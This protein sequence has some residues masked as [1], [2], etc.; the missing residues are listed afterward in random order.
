MDYPCLWEPTFLHH[1]LVLVVWARNLMQGNLVTPDLLTSRYYVFAGHAIEA[2]RRSDT[3]RKNE[4]EKAH[5]PP[6]TQ[7]SR[8]HR[9]T[10]AGAF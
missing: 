10:D 2:E 4:P 3:N 6:D 9:D 5:R 1:Q 7:T 8:I